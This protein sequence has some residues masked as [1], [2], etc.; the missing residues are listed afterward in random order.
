MLRYIGFRD[1]GL[2]FPKARGT[3]FGCPHNK[4]YS[5]LVS[6][7]GSPYFGKLPHTGSLK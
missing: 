1:K 4:A 5:I 6:L 3:L 7:L 2:G